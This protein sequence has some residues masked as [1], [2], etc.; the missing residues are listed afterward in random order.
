MPLKQD[1]NVVVKYQWSDRLSHDSSLSVAWLFNF[2]HAHFK[3]IQAVRIEYFFYIKS[4]KYSMF[5]TNKMF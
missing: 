3:G 1:N 4:C 2:G 5:N